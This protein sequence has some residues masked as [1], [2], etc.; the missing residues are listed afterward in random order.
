MNTLFA[1]VGRV[2]DP[3]K[4]CR[5]HNFR[6]KFSPGLQASV[7]E[8]LLYCLYSE[9]LAV[10]KQQQQTPNFFDENTAFK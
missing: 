5:P 10:V 8:I 7:C 1:A 2:L 6:R 4:T 9:G 3:P